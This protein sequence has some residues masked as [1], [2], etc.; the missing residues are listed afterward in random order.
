MLE[1]VQRRATKLVVG[2]RNLDYSDRLKRLGMTTLEERRLR[3]DLIETYKI[4]SEKERIKKEQFFTFNQTGRGH[5]WKINKPRVKT[6][7]RINFYSQRI[8]NPWNKLNE[9]IISCYS[10]I[11]MKKNLDRDWEKIWATH[12]GSR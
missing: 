5:K 8:I 11:T 7:Q 1:D 10:V 3:G 9:R 2:M 6:T 12:K 4:M